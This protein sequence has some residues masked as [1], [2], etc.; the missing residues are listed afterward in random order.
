M[1]TL[2]VCSEKSHQFGEPILTH[3]VRYGLP[4]QIM[5]YEFFALSVLLHALI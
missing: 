3:A 2:T 5:G 1:T 4:P